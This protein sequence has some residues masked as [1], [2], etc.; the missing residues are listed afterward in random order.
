MTILYAG[1]L[2]SNAFGNLIAAGIVGGMEGKLGIRAWRWLFYIEGAMTIFV[3]LCSIFVL[4]DFPETER[5]LT[6]LE[7]CNIKNNYLLSLN[8]HLNSVN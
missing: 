3:A 8:K 7:V 2:I 5:F 6:P 4:P 1:N